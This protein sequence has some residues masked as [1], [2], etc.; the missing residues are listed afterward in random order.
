MINVSWPYYASMERPLSNTDEEM[1]V[2]VDIYKLLTE[3]EE[4]KTEISSAL[5]TRFE[6]KETMPCFTTRG[7]IRFVAQA[8]SQLDKVI[9]I[10]YLKFPPGLVTY[11]QQENAV[12]LRVLN[13]LIT[14][15]SSGK[16][17][18]TNT[19]DLNEAHEILCKVRDIIN[20]AYAD[21]LKYGK[22]KPEDV[23][24]AKKLSWIEIYKCLPQTN[25]GKC[26]YQTC[27]ALALAALQGGAKLAQCTL[28]KDPRYYINLARL[29]KTLGPLQEKT[30]GIG[31]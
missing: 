3:A 5:V 27:S 19:K 17:G 21:Y 4:K 31:S 26:G 1:A 18:V 29:R 30:Q 9:E 8:D 11:A 10:I 24:A 7:Y 2:G 25:C 28:L 14:I 13:R 12:T 22:P 15:F 20:E 23:E 6:I 16:I